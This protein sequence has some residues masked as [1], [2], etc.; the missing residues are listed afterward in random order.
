MSLHIACTLFLLLSA[1]TL[2]VAAASTPR[3]T[4]DA[5]PPTPPAPGTQVQPGLA[6]P[7]AGVHRDVLLVGGG[8]NFPGKMPWEGG[9]KQW[10]DDLFV[11][12]RHADGSFAW[13]TG[14]AFKLPRKLAYGASFSTAEGVVCAGG[15]DPSDCFADVFMLSWDTSTRRVKATSLPAMPE[16]LA[17][18][19]SAMVGRV[20]YV[21]AGQKTTKD[22]TGT[23]TFW[24]LDLA[25]RDHAESFKWKILPDLPGPGRILPV[26]AAQANGDGDQ[27]YVFSGRS[28]PAGRAS[29]ILSDAYA[30]NVKK[31][32]W[33]QLKDGPTV[34][35]GAAAPFGR[36][37]ILIFSGDKGDLFREL[38]AHD[39]AV[40]AL[41]QKAA[42]ATGDAKAKAEAE[43]N[44][45][46]E[47][48]KK[49]YLSHPGFSRDVIAYDTRQESWKVIGQSPTPG[50]VTTVAVPWGDAILLVGGEVRPAVRTTAIN[51]VVPKS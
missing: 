44:A 3:L 35:A 6:A 40:A 23:T 51:R 28:Q 36:D 15:S 34:M 21:V 37:Q 39:L 42:H 33:R 25:Q 19:S 13:V 50:Q 11:L 45:H 16:P 47:A 29:T 17:F 12:E 1:T 38:E 27:I 2:T 31:G 20:L 26:V 30:F 24:S 48:K 10:C 7:F 8:A 18:M 46:L 32:Q 4:W 14:T 22:A 5:L 43:A 41:R 49:I 9:T